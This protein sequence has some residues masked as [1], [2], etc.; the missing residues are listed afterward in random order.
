MRT[1]AVSMVAYIS[2]KV[3]TYIYGF[4][5]CFFVALQKVKVYL[6]VQCTCMSIVPVFVPYLSV[7]E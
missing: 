1:V 4:F 7:H 5:I 6:C 2:L 3:A